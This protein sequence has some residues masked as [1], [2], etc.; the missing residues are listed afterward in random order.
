MSFLEKQNT[1]ILNKLNSQHTKVTTGFNQQLPNL[2]PRV[3]KINPDNLQLLK[4]YESVTEV[5]N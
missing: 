5:M 4:T 2:G 1:E 3:Q